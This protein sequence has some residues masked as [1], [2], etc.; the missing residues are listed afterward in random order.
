MITLFD[1]GIPR[2]ALQSAILSR[3]TQARCHLLLTHPMGSISSPDPAIAPFEFGMPRLV[4]R[5]ANLSRGTPTGCR[6]LLT[7]PMGATSPPDP[8]TTQ[9]GS[10]IPRLVLQSAN[11]SRGTLTGCCPLPTHQMGATSSP[12][13]AITPFESGMLR[14][15]PQPA[16][17][18]RSSLLLTLWMGATSF[19]SLV[20][21][22][23]VCGTHFHMLPFDLPLVPRSILNFL[24]SP[25][26]TVGSETQRVV[27]YTGYPMGVVQ[28]FIRLP[29]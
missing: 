18:T 27:Y 12:D 8:T 28:P 23:P 4:L 20:P 14:P 6:P 22:L 1:S 17:L 26:W 7:H 10:G 11:L 3:G 24:Q 16:S 9:F 25:T 15:V 21:I 13:P 2:L 5:S 19:L 29:L